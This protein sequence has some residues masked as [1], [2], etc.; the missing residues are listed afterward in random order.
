M[1]DITR[2]PEEWEAIAIRFR[3]DC[4]IV[5]YKVW[6]QLN[7]EGKHKLG[8]LTQLAA[9]RI[10][11]GLATS[12]AV[13]AEMPAALA[14]TVPSW[15]RQRLTLEAFKAHMLATIELTEG[16]VGPASNLPEG[17]ADAIRALPDRAA[18]AKLPKDVQTF[19]ERELA[20]IEV[21][22]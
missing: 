18:L 20:D 16:V 19:I 12:T 8:G 4:A 21:G 7:P 1:A 6:I 22:T 5:P 10:V 13:T 17:Y 11:D 15:P 2:T 3:A 14:G 9:R